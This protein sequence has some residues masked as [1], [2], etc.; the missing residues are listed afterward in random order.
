VLQG[1]LVVRDEVVEGQVVVEQGVITEVVEGDPVYTA[2]DDYGHALITPGLIDVHVH[3]IAGADVMDGTSA[4]IDRMAERFARHGVTG[5]L[6]T[7]VSQSL[8][9]TL[10]AIDSI[11]ASMRAP[12]EGR[13]A[14]L[15]IHLE[16]PFLNRAF[17]GMQHE[18]FLLAP[19]TEIARRLMDAAAGQVRR[20][21]LAPELPGAESVI[22]LCVEAG[23]A[24][25]I[26]HTGATYE[27]AVDAIQRGARHVTHCFNAMTGL[28]HREPG[29]AGAALTE[30]ALI[31][32][33]VADGIH[34]HPAVMRLLVQ[35][36]GRD[37]VMLV[38]DSMSAADMPDGAY[39]F[40]GHEVQVRNGIARLT[41]GTLASSTLTMDGA[42]R[43]MISA[44]GISLTDAIYMGATT[45]A[46]AIGYGNTKGRIA[47][48]YDADLAVFTSSLHP[49]ATWVG[50]RQ[51]FVAE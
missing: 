34:V 32:E 4:S 39:R 50:G 13:A 15:G 20:F 42:V 22:D 8:D 14:I 51:V 44:C 10:A 12:D 38:T 6:P 1:S 5:F 9:L 21:S 2:T 18:D 48:G 24:V 28:H 19:S 16:G 31:A 37:G 30:P 3:G 29:V 25:S 17:K 45:P 11:L 23:I 41:D 35:A 26:A 47:P 33:L 7:T 36:K 46:A 40:G 49:Q 27:G 43:T